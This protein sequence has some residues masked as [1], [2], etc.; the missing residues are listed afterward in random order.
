MQLNFA[1]AKDAKMQLI[2]CSHI[3][4]TQLHQYPNYKHWSRVK[5]KTLRNYFPQAASFDAELT[6]LD[7]LIDGFHLSL[8]DILLFN[9]YVLDRTL[10]I[11]VF[12]Q[13]TVSFS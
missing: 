8:D 11:W 2:Y 4:F 6:N 3:K 13:L 5:V 10:I 7:S 12:A 9:P 1:S